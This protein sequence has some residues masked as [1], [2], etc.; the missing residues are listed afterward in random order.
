MLFKKISEME[1]FYFMLLCTLPSLT[2]F[3][4]PFFNILNALLFLNNLFFALLKST[5]ILLSL[6][7]LYFIFFLI[8]IPHYQYYTISFYFVKSPKRKHKASYLIIKLTP[9]F[10]F[11]T[12]TFIPKKESVLCTIDNPRPVFP[13][14]PFVYGVKTL[15]IKS[16]S[17][18]GPS[19]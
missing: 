4:E 11:L 19:L 8:K 12:I 6:C 7:N 16:L 17:I 2:H 13:F 14:I 1:I 9:F 10:S 18:L 3:L 15:L 5:F